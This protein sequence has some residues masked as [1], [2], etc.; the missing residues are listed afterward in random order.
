MTQSP[1]FVAV[2][3]G[4]VLLLLILWLVTRS[5]GNA[6]A[7]TLAG[8]DAEIAQAKA[9]AA[10]A[11]QLA[12]SN[13]A[14]QTKEANL[15]ANAAIQ[16]ANEKADAAL[17]HYEAEMKRGHEKARTWLAEAQK[18]IDHER[19]ALQ[20]EEVRLRDHYESEARRYRAEIDIALQQARAEAQALQK[21]AALHEAET[22]TKRLLAEAT[23]EAAA[24]RA[25]ATALLE[26]A[27]RA[28]KEERASATRKATELRTQA[29]DLLARATRNAAQIVD[30]AH[31]R[32]EKI[33]GDAYTALREKDDLDRA[34]RAIRNIIDGY[35]DRYVV[36]THSVI[37]D[38]AAGFGHTEAGR[39]LELARQQSKRMVTDQLA[40]AC[41]YAEA[42][43][44][45]TAI[46]FVTDAF[47][48][49]VDALLTE[50]ESENIGTLEQQIRD[51]CYLVNLNG[52]AFR[53]A[54][55][56]PAYLDARL[57][58]LKWAVATYEL[59]QREREEQRRIKEQI[60]EEE[61][62]RR[63]Y[64]RAIREAQDEEAKIQRALAK[65][66][67]EAEQASAQG[68]QRLEQEIAALNQKLAEAEEKNQRA[69]SMAQ[70]TK[71]GN[72]YVIS[73]LGSFGEE[74]FKIGMTRRLEPMDRIWELSDASVPFDFD[75]HAMIPCDDAPA[76]E[77]ALHEAFDEHRINKVNYRKEFFRVSLDRIREIITTR[78]IEASFTLL[79]EA[80]EYRETQKLNQM[81]AEERRRYLDERPIT[82]ITVT[83]VADE[84]VSPAAAR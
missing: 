54:R 56:L 9:D 4:A 81:S 14:T 19:A 75:V 70:Q 31:Q 27:Q 10:A 48:G 28:T 37:D 66:R 68:R 7:R 8:K 72:V 32:A 77:S 59:R 15:R 61:R 29:D 30:E 6:L 43:R 76:L 64:E 80:H 50:A 84:D 24:L 44:R 65:A 52:Q 21:Y 11:V 51:A 57:E 23:Q 71:K 26:A 25:E 33:A 46:R 3:S 63:E 36:P 83:H 5:R 35:G 20:G 82:S 62:A 79:A 73:N 58:E 12:E 55:I 1:L 41:D 13:A 74:I 60:R 17:R 38:L 47:N 16:T 39:R 40:A 45:E 22:E 34:V 53:N 2:F 69:L 67:S 42:N 49:R 78:G 18:L